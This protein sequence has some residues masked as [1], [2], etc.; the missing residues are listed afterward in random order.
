MADK[1]MMYRAVFVDDEPFVIEGLK[2]AIDWEGAN[3][4]IVYSSTNPLSALSYIQCNPVDL[5]ITDVSMPQLSGLELIRLAK[6]ANS[7]LTILVLSAYDNFEYVRTAL[8]NGAENYLLK[9]LDPNELSESISSITEHLKDRSKLSDIY[10][11]T[12][13][14]FRSIFIENWVKGSLEME[15]FLTRAELLGVNLQLHN[16]TVLLFSAPQADV[17]GMAR[18]FDYLLSSFVGNFQSHFYFE[19]PNCLVCILSSRKDT[20]DM[21]GFLSSLSLVRSHLTFPFFVSVGHTVDNYEEVSESYRNAHRYLFLH[22]TAMEFYICQ[23]MPPLPLPVTRTIEQNF[24]R[25]SMEDYWAGL[26]LLL[27][28]DLSSRQRMEFQ[29]AVLNHGIQ[30]TDS[31]STDPKILAKL[32]ELLCDTRNYNRLVAYL[33][34]FV[35]TCYEVLTQRQEF[36]SSAYPYVDAVIQAVHDFSNKEISLKTLASQ[37]NMHPSYLGNIFHQQTGLYF[38]DYLNEERL[39]YAAELME[40][41]T[42][43]LK[44]IVDKTGFSSQTYF[45]R[46]FKRRFGMSPLS[47][48]R[49]IKLRNNP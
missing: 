7:L 13:L 32:K 30:Q 22:H 29:L 21:E 26:S 48:R 41:T 19:T 10:G 37:L 2:A 44:D 24:S 39:K 38:N 5:L 6:E 3:F 43:K 11:S 17:S 47:Y 16:Y 9:P 49:E 27:T 8:R 35:E 15:D 25:I 33:C 18:L 20:P 36:Q 14:T 12:M 34:S 1:K 23:S 46:L 31:G 4:E 42:L 45:N 28:P 40:T